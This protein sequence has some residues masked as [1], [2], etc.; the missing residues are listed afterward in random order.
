MTR[1]CPAGAAGPPR[2]TRRGLRFP[3]AAQAHDLDGEWP[4]EIQLE[5]PSRFYPVG[6]PRRPLASEPPKDPAGAAATAARGPGL[7]PLRVPP[8]KFQ[9][10]P[11]AMTPSRMASGGS[12]TGWGRTRQMPQAQR[13]GGRRSTARP[14][15]ARPGPTRP[16]P[17]R[18]FAP[19]SRTTTGPG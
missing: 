4:P 19:T 15:P 18:P 12:V 14:S 13:T 17:V 9:L 3:L 11:T 1:H 6:P 5:A 8:F 16:G 7:R 2:L 10:Q